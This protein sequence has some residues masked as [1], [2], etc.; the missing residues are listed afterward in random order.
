[1]LVFPFY[2]NAQIPDF[3]YINYSVE[4]GLSHNTVTN[5]QMDSR[6]FLW[7]STIDGLN[8]FD[9]KS[10]KVYKH[11]PND[12]TSISDNF[13][14][15][16]WEDRRGYLWANTR[17]AGINRFD[18]VTETFKRFV[19]KEGV[20]NPIPLSPTTMFFED[21]DGVF[22]AGYYDAGFGIIDEQTESYIPGFIVNEATNDPLGIPNAVVE[23]NDG[24]LIISS[25]GGMY[26]ITKSELDDFKTS[27]IPGDT[28]KAVSFGLLKTNLISHY[29]EETGLLWVED[30]T[31]GV[32]YVPG[33]YIPGRVKKALDS[34]V[35]INGIPGA[36]AQRGNMLLTGTE[37]N[38]IEIIEGLEKKSIFPEEN[39]DIS[40]T[41]LYEDH[42]GTLWLGTWGNGIYRVK[43]KRT[44]PVFNQ[45]N[46]ERL[47]T[48]FMLAFEQENDD[49]L[50]VGTSDGLGLYDIN[51]SRFDKKMN[52][53]IW[54]LS[55]T[56][57]GL[58]VSTKGNGITLIS[59]DFTK[60]F[61]RANSLLK[62]DDVHQVFEDS[63]GW[64]WIGYEGEG[65]QLIT[66][67]T[68]W[69]NSK[70]ASVTDFTKDTP[71]RRM[72]SNTIR[73]FYEDKEGSIWVATNNAGA[74]RIQ[75]G[76][77]QT[78][79]I[80]HF[81]V[82]TETRLSHNAIRSVLQQGD[83]VYWFA[84]HGNGL[85]KWNTNT[86]E[87]TFYTTEQGLPNNTLY[88]VL[89]DKNPD[90][91]WLSTNNGLSR[92]NT[93]ED[94]FQN[95][96]I[97]D[98]LQNQEFNTGAFLVTPEGNLVFGGIEG[99]NVIDPAAI[100]L[101]NRQPDVFITETLLF[102]E[103]LQTDSS[104]L[105][106]KELTLPYNQNFLAFEFAAIDYTDP[107]KN[108]FAYKLEGVDEDW[109]YNGTRNFASYP[110][111]EPN[112][113][114]LK[115]KA[116]NNNGV[117]NELGTSL[118]ITITPPWWATWWFR[119]FAGSALIIIFG[120]TIRYISQRELREQIRQME[121]ANKLKEE[122]TRISRD[123]HDHVGAQLTNITSGLS[124]I[125]KYSKHEQQDKAQELANSLQTDA[126]HTITQ[127]RETIW[128]LNQKELDIQ[129]FEDFIRDY[130]N[131]QS[132]LS[133]AIDIQYDFDKTS[134][135]VLSPT[136]ALN[137]FRI[138]QEA[139]QNSIKYSGANTLNISVSTENGCIK[140][141]VKDNGA[142]KEKE[143]GRTSYGLGN[144]EKRALELGGSL[145]MDTSSGTEV[146]VEVPMN[147]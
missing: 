106:N 90:Y 3:E 54:S 65:I 143:E 115:V 59:D 49:Q 45:E 16:I 88:G 91:I 96:T 84:S 97:S 10:F 63:R 19:H 102:N 62:M 34:G 29:I 4:D 81:N 13:L 57:Y 103:P 132:A 69:L 35:R 129:S 112:T 125:D 68:D 70:P 113:Y 120:F 101:N 23:M 138:I 133:E 8:R 116:S 26:M 131:K 58:W 12:S 25:L 60:V 135:V 79:S 107:S 51:S 20:E 39:E 147:T 5:I 46:S 126:K 94:T 87:T 105:V 93:R 67:P 110:N 78:F 56:D 76:G 40:T 99:F 47:P 18:P 61:N 72:A 24:S 100:D 118:A 98:G 2:G 50:W 104:S 144:M 42:F 21:S 75:I 89:P 124:L 119:T 136:Q 66:N 146:K 73:K 134:S 37:E 7:I 114:T 31:E 14:H 83:E 32:L 128:A 85:T 44:F 109:V 38:G 41:K 127:L 17:D 117:W 141:S 52:G 122:R 95:F 33:K 53:S 64:L 71:E 22:W 108:Q 55:K 6:G 139:T 92:M 123:L 111:L 15:G 145:S 30:S 1:M 77:N 82:D 80:E 137:L 142:F 86:G 27:R 74:H 43:E 36:F 28:L 130:F 121:I 11:D 48:N 140:A 9:G